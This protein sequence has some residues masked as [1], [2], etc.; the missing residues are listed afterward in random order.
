MKTPFLFCAALVLA[1]L[2]RVETA[3]AG[4]PV[5]L[6]EPS[7]IQASSSATTYISYLLSLGGTCSNYTNGVC[8]QVTG[9]G[10]ACFQVYDINHNGSEF[11]G[12]R[13]E[14]GVRLNARLRLTWTPIYVHGRCR[15]VKSNEGNWLDY[16]IPFNSAAEWNAVIA[17]AP[18]GLTLLTCSFPTTL[19]QAIGPTSM[20]SD[21][22]DRGDRYHSVTLPYYPTGYTWPSTGTYN[23]SITD[24]CYKEYK[25]YKCWKTCT[26][27]W[28]EC[29]TVDDPPTCQDYCFFFECGQICSPNSHEECENKSEDYCCDEGST[30]EK[31]WHSW[32]E[33]FALNATA[34]NGEASYPGW[35]ASSWRTSGARPDS[36]CNIRCDFSNQHD[37]YC[38][39][40]S[41]DQQTVNSCSVPSEIPISPA[42]VA[43]GNA[44]PSTVTG[45]AMAIIAANSE[46][47]TLVSLGQCE[48]AKDKMNTLNNSIT[49][50]NSICDQWYAQL[51]AQMGH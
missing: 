42:C 33:T 2:L 3:T 31:E 48:A 35:S 4:P 24:E 30:C 13:G 7:T 37:C 1:F 50:C 28:T 26:R 15:Y 47:D 21:M 6:L 49:N 32:T 38:P 19:D 44:A 17:N 12:R 18:P 41:S 10:G 34:G 51:N 45:I 20:R 9:G 8:T 27:Y 25:Q 40:D 43:Y 46:I 5:C 39:G 29:H 36:T 22:G 14:G 16:F 11:I 23:D